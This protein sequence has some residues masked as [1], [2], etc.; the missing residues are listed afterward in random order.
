[1]AINTARSNTHTHRR[2]SPARCSEGTQ[3]LLSGGQRLGEHTLPQQDAQRDERVGHGRGVWA[4]RVCATRVRT[5]SATCAGQS[6]C[7]AI[8]SKYITI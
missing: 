7:F 2:A 4:T 3:G 5:G 6:I 8:A 1:M